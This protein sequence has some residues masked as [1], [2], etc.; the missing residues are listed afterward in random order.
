MTMKLWAW[1]AAEQNTALAD[2]WTLVHF[3]AGL[4]A[5]MAG[6]SA[7]WAGV[8]AVGYEVF[9]QVAERQPWGKRLFKSP[10]AENY[11]NVVLDVVVFALGWWAGRAIRNP[12]APVLK[13]A[14]K[15]VSAGA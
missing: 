13:A 2:P 5:G 15:Q 6:V 3:S 9:E 10:G 14:P 12:G 11:P 8:V 1:R 7:F 4:A